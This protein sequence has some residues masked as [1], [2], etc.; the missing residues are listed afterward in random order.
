MV[1]TGFYLNS[2]V[3]VDSSRL[4]GLHPGQANYQCCLSLT[5]HK[6]THH[7]YLAFLTAGLNLLNSSF[8]FNF[9]IKYDFVFFILQL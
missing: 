7:R 6:Y 2:D 3:V 4:V 1:C 5:V 8:Y 9:K